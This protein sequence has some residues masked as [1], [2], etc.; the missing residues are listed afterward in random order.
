MPVVFGREVDGQFLGI[1]VSWHYGSAIGAVLAWVG[2][3]LG[4]AQRRL[5]GLSEGQRLLQAQLDYCQPTIA[6]LATPAR[7]NRVLA[8][9]QPC[10]C[11]HYGVYVVAAIVRTNGGF[12]T[13]FT[14]LD[15]S[16]TMRE[17]AGGLAVSVR[18]KEMGRTYCTVADAA[19]QTGEAY[20]R[21]RNCYCF[22]MR[23][24]WLWLQ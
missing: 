17:C 11:M 3:T 22:N 20:A 18:T 16:S 21:M 14:A 13:S 12:A 6:R 7:G 23:R 19:L 5:E 24:E 8:G 2:L 1:A 10:C 15:F 9:T 4:I